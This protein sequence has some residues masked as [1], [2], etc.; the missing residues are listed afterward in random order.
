MVVLLLALA[1]C[2]PQL[3]LGS[4]DGGLNRA[5]EAFVNAVKSKNAEGILAAFSRTTPWQHVTYDVVTKKIQTRNAVTYTQ[6]ELDFRTRKNW[7][8]PFFGSEEHLDQL[9][10]KIRMVRWSRQGT[11]FRAISST[12]ARFYIKWRQEDGRWVIAE[13]G[14]TVS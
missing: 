5:M 10:T 3:V 12:W 11:A 8:K 1:F 14:E 4:D 2:L 6:L 13:I 7:Y 9:H